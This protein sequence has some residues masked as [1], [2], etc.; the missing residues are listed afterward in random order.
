MPWTQSQCDLALPYTELPPPVVI[1]RQGNDLTYALYGG[2]AWTLFRLN[3]ELG[4]CVHSVQQFTSFIE[5]ARAFRVGA[6]VWE[7]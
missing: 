1:L 2:T 7:E 3:I 5:A 6:V 4:T